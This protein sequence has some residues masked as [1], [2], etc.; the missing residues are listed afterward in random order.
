MTKLKVCT[1]DKLN[2]AKMTISHC[3]RLENT[4][5]KEENAGDQHFLLFPQCFQKPSSLGS[6]KVGIVL[7]GKE[8]TTTA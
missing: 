1:D 2:F 6:L 8:L 7:C 4:V 3:A 5:G